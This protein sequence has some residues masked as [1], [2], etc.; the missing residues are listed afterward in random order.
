MHPGYQ[1]TF[2]GGGEVAVG[3]RVKEVGREGHTRSGLE[4]MGL[5]ENFMAWWVPVLDYFVFNSFILR[6]SIVLVQAS[7]A[8]CSSYASGLSFSK[9]QC[10]VLG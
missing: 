4:I 2:K 3:W 7:S 10:R 6:N 9:N 1:R 5:K 8:A